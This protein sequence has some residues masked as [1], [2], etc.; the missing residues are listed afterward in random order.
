MYTRITR[1]DLSVSS[2]PVYTMPLVVII[3]DDSN[4]AVLLFNMRYSSPS[5]DL[6]M[7]QGAAGE[8]PVDVSTSLSLGGANTLHGFYGAM[9]GALPAPSLQQQSGFSLKKIGPTRVNASPS[10]FA[11]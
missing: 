8:A 9:T 7:S 11:F 3:A 1:E 2:H 10:R 5:V 6:F 4:Y